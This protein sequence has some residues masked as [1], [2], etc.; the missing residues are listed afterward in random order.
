MPEIAAT[1]SPP[2]LAIS[3]FI[4]LYKPLLRRAARQILQGRLLDLNE[5]R[6]GRWLGNDVDDWLA[7]VWKR[8]DE[9]LPHAGLDALPDLGN[10][11]NVLL[12]VITTAAYQTM[13]ERTGE[14]DYSAQLVADVGWKLYALGTKLASLPFRLTSRDPGKR[15][16][17]T[18]K[19]LLIFPFS[20]PGRPGYEVKVWRE[21]DEL[22][23]HWTWCPPQ[24]YVRGLTERDGDR[25]ELDAFYR[26]WCLYDWPGADLIAGDGEH[27]H[28]SRRLT[29]S[30][31]DPV[32]D[33]CWKSKAASHLARK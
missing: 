16:E 33:M 15:M 4:R 17:R 32:C 27:G 25:G 11:H 12:A 28:Y 20:A 6:K 10:R 19:L 31:G 13:A 23:T 21:G 8:V 18:I 1:T 14:Q 3:I 5:P 2:G 30:R 7:A 29:M 9:L 24:A 22:M 26:S